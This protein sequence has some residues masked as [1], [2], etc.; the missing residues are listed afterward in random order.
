MASVHE[1][2][3]SY[4]RPEQEMASKMANR[5]VSAGQKDPIKEKDTGKP[6]LEEIQYGKANDHRPL[7]QKLKEQK[8]KKDAEWKEANDP[9]KI[10]TLED[11]EI[12]FLDQT[13]EVERQ[14]AL[15]RKKLEQEEEDQFR[16]AIASRQLRSIEPEEEK[17]D[18]AFKPATHPSTKKR[19]GLLPFAVVAVKSKDGAP[20]APGGLSPTSSNP[21][22]ATAQQMAEEPPSKKRRSLLDNVSDEKECGSDA[23][24]SDKSPGGGGL[25]AY[26]DS[27]SGSGSGSEGEASGS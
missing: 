15:E 6:A 22:P 14:K 5:F 17:L 26:G 1:K 8:D 12:E 25:V 24:G 13:S 7:W 23:S 10:R 9:F 21:E 19:K 20:P 27:D 16:M 18:L 2:F 3:S 11:D 4:K